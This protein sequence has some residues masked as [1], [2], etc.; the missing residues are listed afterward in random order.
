[1]LIFLLS[2]RSLRD[3]KVLLLQQ[4]LILAFKRIEREYILS[5][6]SFHLFIYRINNIYLYISIN[7]DYL[8]K[9]L[10]IINKNYSIKKILF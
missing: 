3:N 2:Y 9:K 4:H 10:R 1:M 5:L 8:K 7:V 6:F